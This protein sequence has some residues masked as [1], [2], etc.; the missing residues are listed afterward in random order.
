MCVGAGGGDPA[1]EG[2][3]PMLRA[4]F[5]GAGA[6]VL[7]VSTALAPVSPGERRDPGL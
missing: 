2:A 6:Q 1:I 4:A 7:G 3:G 5:L